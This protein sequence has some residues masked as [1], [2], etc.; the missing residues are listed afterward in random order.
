[1]D[2]KNQCPRCFKVF[3]S[4]RRLTSHVQLQTNCHLKLSQFVCSS[5]HKSFATKYCLNRHMEKHT[6]IPLDNNRPLFPVKLK[7]KNNDPFPYL[8]THKGIEQLIQ[9]NQKI[10]ELIEKQIIEQKIITEEQNRKIDHLMHKPQNVINNLQIICISK[11]DNYLDMLTQQWGF[12]RAIEYIK[13][14]ALSSLTGDCK[15]IQKIYIENHHDSI[16]YIDKKKTKIQYFDENSNQIIENKTQF[17]RRIANNLQNSYLKGVNY[18]INK[19]LES[20]GCPNKFLDDYDIQEWNSHIYNLSD[21]KYQRKV[22]NQLDIP[23]Q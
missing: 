16:N 17:G 1:M 3:S 22:V 8:Q 4:Q 5:C 14:C 2:I 20:R 11:D 9:Q 13:D 23:V 12:D 10:A 18:L 21:E 19:N 15:L 6:Q 7:L